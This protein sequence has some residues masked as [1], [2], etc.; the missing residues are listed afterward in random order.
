MSRR[1]SASADLDPLLRA[2]CETER[3]PRPAELEEAPL[4]TDWWLEPEEF[5]LRAAGRCSG[6]P[7]IDHPY[8][9]TSPVI[10]LDPEC[11]WMR[12]RS[13]FYRLGPPFDAEQL[14]LMEPHI[15]RLLAVLRRKLLEL[16]S[17]SNEHDGLA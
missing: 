8:V 14:S 3:G 1:S 9:T 13:R 11:R 16:L 10:G 12:T 17:A 2:I 4:L 15:Q 7:T 5:Y 6:H